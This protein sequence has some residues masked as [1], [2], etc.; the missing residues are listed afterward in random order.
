[1]FPRNLIFY[2]LFYSLAEQVVI[3]EELLSAYA[4]ADC[5]K[6]QYASVGWIPP[7]GSETTALMHQSNGCIW[8]TM[9]IQ[10]KNIPSSV[11]REEL[12]RRVKQLET[13]ENRKVSGREKKDL[14]E[15]IEFELLP[16]AFPKNKTIDGWLD[17]NSMQLF[18]AASSSAQAERFTAL[19]RK[20][21]F[22]LPIQAPETKASPTFAMTHWLSDEVTPPKFYL[23]A[24]C[25]LYSQSEDKSIATFKKHE[26][27]TDE[28]KTNLS[29][30]KLVS[31]LGLEWDGKISF[32]LADDLQLK[33][34]KFL[35]VFAEQVHERDPQSHEE[36][37]DV[38]FTLVT[39]EVRALVS[40]LLLA[41]NGKGPVL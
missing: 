22:S 12:D 28:V 20:T 2:S 30:G 24:E 37:L 26:L 27:L 16:H 33:R 10:E 38:E 6:D 1:M 15:Q 3:T 36:Q 39:G 7:L 32:V 8:I 14:R 41:L 40:D 5:T 23:G 9:K 25:Q 21:L 29:N 34:I 18:V 4:F 31:Q 19:L 35:D 13:A 11:V 17:T